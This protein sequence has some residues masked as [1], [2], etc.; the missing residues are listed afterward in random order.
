[1][2]SK[3]SNP[4]ITL[5]PECFLHCK[6]CYRASTGAG[7]GH[8]GRLRLEQDVGVGIA[9][10]PKGLGGRLG[11][12]QRLGIHWRVSGGFWGGR[13]TRVSCHGFISNILYCFA[14]ELNGLRMVHA[15]LEM[16]PCVLR[17]QGPNWNSAA[18]KLKP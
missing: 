13:F 10:L 14:P 2:K 9:Q 7:G 15:G 17:Y 3:V 18:L 5:F 16:R 6:P 11:Q 8:R 1:M 4:K 12:V